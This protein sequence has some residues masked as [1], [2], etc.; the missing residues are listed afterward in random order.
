MIQYA[1]NLG[2]EQIRDIICEKSISE[3]GKKLVRKIEPFEH[4]EDIISRQKKI[5]AIRDILDENEDLPIT[6]FNDI[7]DELIRCKVYGT[8]FEI[9]TLKSLRLILFL[10]NNLKKYFNVHSDLLME[11]KEIIQDL[12]PLK[13]INGHINSILNDEDEIKDTASTALFD[14]RKNIKKL[15][16]KLQREISRV[17]D[18]AKKQD[19]LSEDNPTIRNGRLVL[20]LKADAK[21]KIKGIVHGQS[22]TGGTAYLEPIVLVEIN[23]RLNDLEEK[24]KF[25]IKKILTKI[26]DQIRPHFYD[27]RV[28][29]KLLSILDFLRACAVYSKEYDCNPPIVS[30]IDRE[31]KLINARHPLLA[32][33]KEV[34]PLNFSVPDKYK[35]VL[36][37]G[38]NAGGK[39]VAMKTV[40]LLGEMAMCGLHVPAD[41]SS[42]IPFYDKFLVDIG[43]FQSI[44][45]DLSTFSSHVSHLKL[46]IDMASDKSL[47]L[48]D[49][50]GTG[51]DPIEGSTLG[52]AV[53]EK[54]IE[55][56]AFTIATTHHSSL[57]AF[58]DANENVTNGA[59]DFN[60][61]TLSPTY[62]FRLGIPGSSYALEIAKRLGVDESVIERAQELL[63]RDRVKLENLLTEVD[64]EKTKLEKQRK[65]LEQNKR[66]L[67][68]LVG[69]YDSKVKSIKI[70]EAKFNDNFTT[71]LEN[72]VIK[73]RIEIEKTV[74]KIKEENATKSTIINAKK[75]V[76]KIAE[77]VKS[78][79]EKK[80]K[81]IQKIETPKVFKIGDYVEITGFGK[82]G[83]I[84]K[85]SANSNRIGVD[86]D[87]K[88]LWVDKKSIKLTE[89]EN[90]ETEFYQ[91]TFLSDM[92]TNVSFRFDMRGMRY[93]EARSAL[94]KYLDKV[95]LG[96]FNE[97][98]IIHGKG[99]GALQKMT[100]EL[101]RG[102]PGVKDFYFENA[103]RGGTGATIVKL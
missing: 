48:I 47:I 75:Q 21:R 6:D 46:F 35:I 92:D 4:I 20:P 41:F 7:R 98:E 88:I 78:K 28:N 32:L 100:T 51:T 67:D 79:K 73:S 76:E 56:G 83:V 57:K 55:I 59:M 8:Y 64:R 87:G 25:E 90:Q 86:L 77:K 101:L 69:E 5:S 65:G 14:I 36:I 82:T 68:K 26:T 89:A 29:I 95:M 96:G 61:S 97:V 94:I 19:W 40:G 42:K 80:Q 37:T 16:V 30:N 1:E 39:T 12:S 49:E 15:M 85:I 31:I 45:N 22:A 53:L 93:D 10:I 72:L 99:S 74:K 9:K 3:S 71:E 44:E 70:K 58:A 81:I 62:T 54:L 33:H 34:V 60:T 18:Y 50:L 103:D 17:M 52:Q 13:N 91:S 38:P 2:F 11:I 24:E 102:Y 23:N 27:I 66:T 43:D 84:E 63:G